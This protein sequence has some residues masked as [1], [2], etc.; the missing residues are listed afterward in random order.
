MRN[1]I[2]VLGA[3]GFLAISGAAMAGPSYT[4][5]VITSDADVYDSG[6]EV[7]GDYF[8][9][10]SAITVNGV[11][12]TSTNGIPANAS[13]FSNG[14]NGSVSSLSSSLN[15]LLSS[16][17]IYQTGVSSTIS[18]SGLASGVTYNFEILMDVP[19]NNTGTNGY[20][21][22]QGDTFN[23]ITTQ[24]TPS[25][26]DAS[27]TATGSTETVT[28]GNGISSNQPDRAQFEAVSLIQEPVPEPGSM[29]ILATGLACLGWVRL[30]CRRVPEPG[31]RF[32][33]SACSGSGQRV[34]HKFGTVIAERGKPAAC[35][36]DNGTN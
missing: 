34:G 22:I 33:G 35:V 1:M 20:V 11:T 17:T 2:L 14:S 12:F 21:T 23:W 30:R 13:G 31:D 5:G 8:G 7:F 6:T 9:N 19:F 18:L 26:L 10:G 25:F 29:T 27:F 15:A 4:A 24:G 36:Y 3:A 28:F 16:P 32:R